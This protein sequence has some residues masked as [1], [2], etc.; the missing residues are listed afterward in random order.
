MT[1]LIDELTPADEPATEDDDGERCAAPWISWMR[2]NGVANDQAKFAA[3]VS[4][5]LVEASGSIT[6]GDRTF[7]VQSGKAVASADDVAALPVVAPATG[8]TM[9]VGDVSSVRQMVAGAS[10]VDASALAA[11]EG[12]NLVL[13]GEG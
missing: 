13:G 2:P 11:D 12:G 7:A 1:H 6:E 4:G 9:T 8:S 3:I 10:V 5:G